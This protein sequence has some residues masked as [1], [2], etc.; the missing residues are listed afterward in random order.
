[1]LQR[2]VSYH[3]TTSQEQ[4]GVMRDRQQAKGTLLVRHSP[5]VT[6]PKYSSRNSVR[7]GNMSHRLGMSFEARAI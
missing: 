7:V 2:H 1:M 6:A 3:W 4:L 5:L